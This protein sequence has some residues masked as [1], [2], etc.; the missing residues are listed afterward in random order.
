MEGLAQGIDAELVTRLGAMVTV[1]TTYAGGAR[2]LDDL[3]LVD[4]LGQ[5]RL[6]LTIGSALDLFGGAGVRYQD[7]VA[8]NRTREAARPT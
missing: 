2:T 8:W 6:D 1:P 5:G 7:A 3:D 4:R